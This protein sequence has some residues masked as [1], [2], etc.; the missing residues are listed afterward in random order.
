MY[1]SDADVLAAQQYAAQQ[2]GMQQGTGV[3]PLLAGISP[4]NPAYQ[5]YMQ[6]Q[7]QTQMF[8]LMQSGLQTLI[9]GLS[10]QTASAG[11]GGMESMMAQG[12]Q[13]AQ[14]MGI[15]PSQAMGMMQQMMQSGGAQ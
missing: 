10:G 15:D 8:G 4:T 13:Q 11:S 5:R 2:Q 14:Q 1:A 12:M 6:V 3:D 7:Q 9:S